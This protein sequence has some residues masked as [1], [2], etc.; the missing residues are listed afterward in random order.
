MLESE[1]KLHVLAS[2]SE[3]ALQICKLSASIAVETGDPE[4]V[5]VAM[6]AALTL[7]R[8]VESDAYRWSEELSNR[9]VDARLHSEAKRLL[10]RASSRWQG[11]PQT[12]DYNGDLLWQAFQ[13]FATALGVN[14]SD[15]A[16]PLVRGLKLAA[17][18]DNPERVL[19]YCEHLIVTQGA[20]GPIARR[21]Q[22]LFNT[23]RAASKVLHCKLHALH[24]EGKELDPTFESFKI[25]HCNSCPDRKPRSTNWEFTESV[26][27]ELIDANRAFVA[28]LVGTQFGIRY[29]P[30]D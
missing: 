24:L 15:D 22:Q 29:T 16:D 7:T 14:T 21:I 6:L 3:S 2:F 12:G 8:S 10:D 28:P 19:A 17:K 13:N 30:E 18:D 27:N 1:G 11:K 23:N 20:T 4:G 9:F 25:A 5:L 26:A